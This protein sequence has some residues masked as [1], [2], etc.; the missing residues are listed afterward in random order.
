MVHGANALP[1]WDWRP[2]MNRRLWQRSSRLPPTRA[3]SPSRAEHQRAGLD[4]SSERPSRSLETSRRGAPTHP[5]TD[6]PSHAPELSHTVF[7][8]GRTTKFPA[9]R[10]VQTPVRRVTLSRTHDQHPFAH[11]NPRPDPELPERDLFRSGHVSKGDDLLPPDW[12]ENHLA[13]LDP[14]YRPVWDARSRDEQL[15][16]ALY[17]LPHQSSQQMLARPARAWSSGIVR[18][19]VS[20]SFVP[21]IVTASTSTPAARM[22]VSIVMP[23]P[24]NRTAPPAKAISRSCCR[25]TWR[26]WTGLTSLPP[27]ST[28]PTAPT[29]SSPWKNSPATPKPLWKASS[30]GA[31]ALPP[32]CC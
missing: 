8:P 14:R 16:L 25:R 27:P 15:A 24:M 32:W 4:N 19:R 2:P 1:F 9:E 12:L 5:A 28:C 10:P 26:T 3:D 6:T 31:T 23:P 22:V 30:P 21:G 13:R 29:L 11:M 18:L 7:T 17:F 20:R